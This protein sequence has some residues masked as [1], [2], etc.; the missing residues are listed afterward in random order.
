MPEF[1]NDTETL[2]E[3]MPIDL[4][5]HIKA[6]KQGHDTELSRVSILTII[7]PKVVK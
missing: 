2:P 4:K 5:N 1:Y 6:E 3:N 7:I